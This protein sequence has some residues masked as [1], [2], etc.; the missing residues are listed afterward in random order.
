M[1]VMVVQINTDDDDNDYDDSAAD[2][3][4]DDGEE[5]ASRCKYASYGWDINSIDSMCI[6]LN[7]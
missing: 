6:E 4:N 5:S 3:D 1:V 2:D 7:L